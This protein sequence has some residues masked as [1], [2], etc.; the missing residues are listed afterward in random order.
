M[1][2][3][4]LGG[5]FDPIHIAH[6]HAGE[7]ALHQAQLDEMLFMPVGDPW[8]KADRSVTLAPHRLEMV[9]LAT[10]DIEGF[11]VD[12]REIERDGPTYT[13]DTLLSFPDDQELFL[14]LG[15]DAALGLPTWRRAV[16]VLE[17]SGILVVP[18][19]GV[20]SAAVLQVVPQAVFLDMA[21]L[22][23]SG[24]EIRA[25]AHRGD[26]FRFLVT[27]RVHEYIVEHALYTEDPG[28][29]SVMGPPGQE[30]SS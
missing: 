19:P 24:T 27:E 6:L 26:P 9:R 21:E 8:Q 29:D 1:R 12:G 7:I 3:G 23:V 10:K 16:D 13:I 4:I 22:E 17:R 11:D 5:T 30:E 25:M 18:R 15:A 28:A 14:V 20:D 2:T